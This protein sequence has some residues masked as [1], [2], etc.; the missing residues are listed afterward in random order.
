MVQMFT[1]IWMRKK[2]K[3]DMK[4]SYEYFKGKINNN[5]NQSRNYHKDC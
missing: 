1:W 2:R 4:E 5:T 3:K